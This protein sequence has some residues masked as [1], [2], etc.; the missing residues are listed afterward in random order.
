MGPDNNTNNINAYDGQAIDPASIEKAH[1]VLK[2]EQVQR[3]PAYVFKEKRAPKWHPL[4]A[5]G[6]YIG[7][8][9]KHP[10][11]STVGL[12]CVLVCLSCLLWTVAMIGEGSKRVNLRW[13]KM[14]QSS[15]YCELGE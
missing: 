12:P 4:P 13:D 14:N 3:E 5:R 7:F 10:Q 11:P 2:E 1:Q 15:W 6:D 9:E 8:C